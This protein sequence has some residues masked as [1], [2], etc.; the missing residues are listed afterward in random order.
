MIWGAIAAR[1]RCGLHF[2]PAGETVKTGNYLSIIKEKVP[3]FS[4]MRET[5]I[6]QQDNA[7]AHRAKI[8][9]DW[10]ANQPEFNVLEGW[11]GNSPD[12]LPIENCWN[13]LKDKLNCDTAIL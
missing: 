6:F 5:S 12:L 7:P 13:Y 1:G 3:Q 2:I 10:I 11:P 8:V 9:N 4:I